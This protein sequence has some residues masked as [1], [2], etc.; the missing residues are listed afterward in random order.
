MMAEAIEKQQR[1]AGMNWLKVSPAATRLVLRWLLQPA[2]LG[3]GAGRSRERGQ[4]ARIQ[5]LLQLLSALCSWTSKSL[6]SR[7]ESSGG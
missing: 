3:N 1:Y 4:D 6:R 7:V 2:C 5:G